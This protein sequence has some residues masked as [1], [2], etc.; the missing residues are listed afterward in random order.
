MLRYKGGKTIASKLV[1]SIWNILM[2]GARRHVQNK[3][4]QGKFLHGSRCQIAKVKSAPRLAFKECFKCSVE[5]NMEL[6]L[7]QR[8]NDE[9][10]DAIK[11]DTTRLLPCKILQAQRR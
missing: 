10:C 5:S 1:P 7:G 11:H 9:A 3:D 8:R 2:F 6:T 4:T